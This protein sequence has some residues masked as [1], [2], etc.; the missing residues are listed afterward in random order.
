MI[1]VISKDGA[2]AKYISEPLA[3]AFFKAFRG[4]LWR[5]GTMRDPKVGDEVLGV[6]IL[7]LTV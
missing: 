1:V 5:A 3:L 4:E 2:P 6:K 7:A